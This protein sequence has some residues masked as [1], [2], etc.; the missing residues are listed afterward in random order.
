MS[1]KQKD[2]NEA[3][4]HGTLSNLSQLSR[5]DMLAIYYTLTDETN[6]KLIDAAFNFTN[7]YGSFISFLVN[8]NFN[9]IV[10]GTHLTR[11]D[12]TPYGKQIRIFIP[13]IPEFSHTEVIWNDIKP[14]E[15]KMVIRNAVCGMIHIIFQNALVEPIENILSTI[16]Q[17]QALVLPWDI[18]YPINQIGD[19]YSISSGAGEFT[20][21]SKDVWNDEPN[22]FLN[23]LMSGIRDYYFN[24]NN[25]EPEPFYVDID[26]ETGEVIKTTSDYPIVNR[27]LGK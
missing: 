14:D 2:A 15:I 6:E 18:G 11:E 9:V 12:E 8:E 1:T 4:V 7:K 13:M 27:L 5:L 16:S 24:L 19:Y 25:V 23:A 21:C 26:E 22:D 3:V 17:G 20:I 10:E